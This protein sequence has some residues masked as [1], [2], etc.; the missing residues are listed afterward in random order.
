MPRGAARLLRVVQ[1]HLDAPL[2]QPRRHI[3]RPPAST[4]SSS[5]S[6]VARHSLCRTSG[7]SPHTTLSW[8]S[9]SLTNSI[10]PPPALFGPL[11]PSRPPYRPCLRKRRTRNPRVDR[12]SLAQKDKNSC[13]SMLIAS[14]SK[15]FE[16]AERHSGC[17]CG[18]PPSAPLLQSCPPLSCLSFPFPLPLSSRRAFPL[19]DRIYRICRIS[20]GRHLALLRDM[21]PSPPRTKRIWRTEKNLHPAALLSPRFLLSVLLCQ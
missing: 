9:R 5:M 16:S 7:T 12:E 11:F 1:P 14:P 17:S 18:C 10:M 13:F 8:I 19:F 2:H 6:A 4:C 20:E 15:P 21:A 3:V